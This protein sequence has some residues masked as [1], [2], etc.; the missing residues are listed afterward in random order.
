MILFNLGRVVGT[1]AALAALE[2]ARVE[3]LELLG[4][5]QGGDWGVVP[6]EDY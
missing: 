6:A 3:P 5:H 2:E 4:R 1:P